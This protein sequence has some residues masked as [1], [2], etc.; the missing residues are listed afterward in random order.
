MGITMESI[1][2]FSSNLLGHI[3]MEHP[4][5]L[6]ETFSGVCDFAKY[7]R[8]SIRAKNVL[9][10]GCVL[11]NTDFVIG[12]VLNTGHDT[13]IMMSSTST[14]SKT[15][16]LETEAAKQI[17]RIII[18][19][20]IIC[21]TG[22]TGQAVWNND[23]PVAVQD[24]WY[25]RW[26]PDEGVI[27][28]NQFFYFFLLHATFIPVSLYVSMS[29][30]RFFQSKFM[31]ADLAMYDE[32]NDTPAQVRT[33]TLNEE[34]GQISHIFSDKTGTL[35]C[36]VM[37]F[38]KVTIGGVSY[39]EG[40]TEIGKVAWK[41][42][43]KT[44]PQEILEYEKLAKENSTPHVS[45]YCPKYHK[46][47][48][49][50]KATKI[51]N[52]FF[53]KV[54]ATCHDIITEKTKTGIVLSA[55][56]PD[57][58]ATVAAAKYFG[59]E[60]LDT[61]DKI[62]S[63]RNHESGEIEQMELLETLEFTSRRKRMSVIVRD[64]VTGD[65]IMMTK[66]ADSAIL[67]R[68]ATCSSKQ[69][70]VASKSPRGYTNGSMKSILRLYQ[71]QGE[72]LDSTI[73]HLN[74]YAVEGLRCLLVTCKHLQEET[75]LQWQEKYK[76][77]STNLEIINMMKRGEKNDIEDLENEIESDLILLGGTAM[78]D[79]LQDGVPDSIATLASAG[80]KIWMLTGDKE[81]T[82]INIA[83][84]CNLLKPK[85]Y[86]KHVIVNSRACKSISSVAELFL[87]EIREFDEDM[88]TGRNHP[89]ALIIDGTV[90]VDVMGDEATKIT[91]L[92]FGKRCTAVVACRVSPDQK[93]EMIALIKNGIEGARTLAVGDG[94][95]DVAMIQAAHVGVGVKG[96]EGVQAVNSADFAIAKFRFLTPLLLKHG[97]NNYMRLSTLVIYMFYKNLYMSFCQFWFAFFNGFSGQKYYTEGGIQL[98]NTVFTSIPILVLGVIDRDLSYNTV[99]KY[100]RIYQYCVSNAHFGNRRFWLWVL[101]GLLE[102][103]MCAILP[104]YLLQYNDQDQGAS[105]TFWE[106]G[107]SCFTTVVVICNLKI[108][109]LQHCVTSISMITLV[110]SVLSWVG[111][112]SLINETIEVD[113]NWCGVWYRSVQSYTF[114]MILLI[115]VSL[116]TLKDILVCHLE[117]SF[118][119]NDG[120]I[121]QEAELNKEGERKH[122]RIQ[123][124]SACCV[125]RPS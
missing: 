61:Q 114:W 48:E 57:D 14:P 24:Q 90:L 125:K 16:T 29:A 109:V 75:F 47:M 70:K 52:C 31:N 95:N 69:M 58:E 3:E 124:T 8:E 21:F 34:L 9:L 115:T 36:N 22:A 53:Y 88:T 106:S 102:S 38:R 85:E 79:R 76:F 50:E 56:N 18:L 13:K 80:I 4:N 112:A 74:Q 2:H 72:I 41:L 73:A 39:G 5:K 37:D 60:F 84:A 32:A 123:R 92:E 25:L 78:E 26:D 119:V 19:L 63:I 87:N 110:L 94:A 6:I 59:F 91:L 107:S 44:I 10:R 11:R 108:L 17:K 45:F 62:I 12:I 113:Y 20:L 46:M 82:A 118:F 86:M 99:I 7:G 28:I 121:L 65:I 64:L 30:V 35:T 116:A 68:L 98:F 67:E 89:R 23:L 33:M 43:G 55:S 51:R 66:G 103:V 101:N 122:E 77:A 49:T 97:R 104:L 93:K 54:L 71:D 111:V 96:E 117:R 120:L 1:V 15:S 42:Q 105:A 81:E 27:W 100:P 83:I 40:I